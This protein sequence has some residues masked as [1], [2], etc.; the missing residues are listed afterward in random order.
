MLP[1]A[2]VAGPSIILLPGFS[3]EQASSIISLFSRVF[4]LQPNPSPPTSYLTQP[5]SLAKQKR[6]R[7]TR[8]QYKK[9][10]QAKALALRVTM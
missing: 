6:N 5:N 10:A 7:K 1:N 4:N 3:A 2:A 9:K 8:Q